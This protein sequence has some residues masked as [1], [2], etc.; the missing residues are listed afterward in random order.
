MYT[1]AELTTAIEELEQGRHTIQNVA[2]LAALYTVRNN[3]QGSEIPLFR[4]SQD[5]ER[6]KKDCVGLYGDSDFLKR[7]HGKN[8]EEMWLMM[9][10]VMNSICML[11]PRL[12]NSVINRLS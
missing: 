1:D 9:D 4:Y 2:K 5:A 12:Y 8:T 11:N 6:E 10:D 7:I 3:L